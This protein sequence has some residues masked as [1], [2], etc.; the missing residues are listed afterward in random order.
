MAGDFLLTLQYCNGTINIRG[1][2]LKKIELKTVE[3][4]LCGLFVAL[5]SV[6]SLIKI[7]FF[8][9]PLTLQFLFVMLCGL[10]LGAKLSF[11]TL[12][13][14][15]FAGIIGLPVFSGGGGVTYVFSLTFGYI[16]G[17]CVSAPIIGYISHKGELTFKKSLF[18]NLVGI[19]TVYIFGISYYLIIST[20]YLGQTVDIMNVFVFCFAVFVPSDV[21]FCVLSS[22]IACRLKKIIKV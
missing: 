21:L 15:L 16:I 4:M 3:I 12:V 8:G 9:I 2:I 19:L 1:V 13:C 11:I 6:G 7:P 22:F 20:F 5:I 10:L 17:F 14:Y 18:A